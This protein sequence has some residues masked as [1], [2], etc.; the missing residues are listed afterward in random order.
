M[1]LEIVTCCPPR[2]LG[3]YFL[4]GLIE[5][6]S[7]NRHAIAQFRFPLTGRPVS[8][9]RPMSEPAPQSGPRPEQSRLIPALGIFSVGPGVADNDPRGRNRAA[10]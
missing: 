5:I 3:G 2:Y 9:A 7:G 6:I 10:Q 8:S 4:S 1:P